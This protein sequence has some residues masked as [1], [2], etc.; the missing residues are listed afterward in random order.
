M[1]PW[2]MSETLTHHSKRIAAAVVVAPLIDATGNPERRQAILELAM[3]DRA[4][5]LAGDDSIYLPYVNEDDGSAPTGLQMTSQM[6]PALERMG[7]AV[8]NR[9][10]V[11]TYYR[12]MSWSVLNLVGYIA[13]TPL[14]MVTPEFDEA[15][16]TAQQLDAFDRMGEPKELDILKGKGHFDWIFGDV[17]GIL[18]TQLDFLKRRMGF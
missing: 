12:A 13:P 18:S 7:V 9:V 8:E 4:G 5:R 15:C 6:I 14:L 17:D 10:T 2:P 16:P 3:Y 1:D 11:Q